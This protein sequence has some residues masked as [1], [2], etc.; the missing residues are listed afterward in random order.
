MA[1]ILLGAVQTGQAASFPPERPQVV[2][3]SRGICPGGSAQLEIAYDEG[4]IDWIQGAGTLSCADCPDPVA[5]PTETTTYRAVVTTPFLTDTLDI[6]ISLFDLEAGPDRTVCQGE[7]LQV[8]AAGDYPNASIAWVSSP[9]SGLDFSCLDCP[10]PIITAASPGTYTVSVS[11]APDEGA[12]A[13]TDQFTLTVGSEPAP[14]YSIGRREEGI[15]E[16]ESIN[17]GVTNFQGNLTFSWTS[18]PAGFTGNQPNFS[19]SPSTTTLYRVEIDN[20]L[21]PTPSVDSVLVRV[22]APPLANVRTDTA[23]CIGDTILLGPGPIESD[24]HY[25][26]SG[27]DEVL[28]PGNPLSAAVP[29]QSGTYTLNAS[30]NGCTSTAS[31]SVD[32]NTADVEIVQGDL[33]LLCQDSTA[34]LQAQLTGSGPPLTINWTSDDPAFT[35]VSGSNISV[36][37]LDSTIYRASIQAGQC[38][39]VDSILVVVDSLPADL[40]ISPAD[41][42]ICEGQYV[43]LKTPAYETSEYPNIT[44]AWRPFRGQQ[45]PDSLLNM[46][47]TPDTTTTYYRLTQNGGCRDSAAAVITVNP[48]DQIAIIP[49]DT[50]VCVGEQVQFQIEG[51]Q[52]LEDIQWTPEQNLSCTDCPDPTA[53]AVNSITYNVQAEYEGCPLSAA[54]NLRVTPA[55]AINLTDRTLICPGEAVQLNTVFDPN[56]TYSWTS[57]DP[58]FPENP[59][60]ETNPTLTVRPTGTTTY[61]LTA[62]N[63]LC[64]PVT[65]EV[66]ID[67]VSFGELNVSASATIL[68]PGDAA[69]LTADLEGGTAIDVYTW[70]GTDGTS[71]VGPEITVSPQQTTTYSVLVT[72]GPNCEQLTAE[73]TINVIAVDVPNAFTPNGD[74][75]NDFFNFTSA[76]EVGEVLRFQVFNRWGQLVYDNDSAGG[77]D[78][79]KDGNPQPSDVYAYI[80]IIRALDGEEIAFRGDV[81][82]I[83]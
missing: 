49:S 54:T 40:S 18:E 68:R 44:F 41:T 4:S 82:L 60:D 1:A 12:C 76:G 69:T 28:D 9:A 30:R 33:F 56:A 5:S 77:W 83:R 43:I 17:I 20:G 45:S 6:T 24:V 75:D 34:L 81:T 36:A 74:G 53:I 11:L 57:T 70:V 65:A 51:P 63:G 61:T 26:W 66:T 29:Q 67:V 13:Q 14:D 50:T 73:I 55:P 23:L 15:C 71:Y 80:I 79:R 46:V 47:V 64:E 32:V 59:G 8:V 2:Q 25:T 62:D 39:Q 38:F 10:D 37:P 16:G 3:G 52:G 58:D 78:G 42:T 22:S 7:Q 72:V 48:I 19:V 27:P 31:F 21:C 35:P